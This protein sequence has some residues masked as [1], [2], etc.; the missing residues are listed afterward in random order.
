MDRV[1]SIHFV[2]GLAALMV[3]AYHLQPMLNA[4]FGTRYVSHLGAF[5]VDLFFVVSG[6]VMFIAAKRRPFALKR[7]A[8]ARFFRIVPLYWLAT[9]VI[10]GLFWVGF[11]PNGL[12]I[13]NWRILVRSLLFIPSEFERGRHDL[14][15]SLGW[16]L[17]YE[18]FFYGIFAFGSL[19]ETRLRVYFF[20][21]SVLLTAAW[22]GT[23]LPSDA[24]FLLTYYTKPIV[25]EF[26]Y[27]GAIA[28]WYSTRG[29]RKYDVL[30]AAALASSALA[31]LTRPGYSEVGLSE[32]RFL[33]FGLPAASLVVAG[34]LLEGSIARLPERLVVRP[35]SHLGDISYSLYLFHPLV[36]QATVKVFALI[37]A[38][39]ALF[40]PIAGFC[41]LIAAVVAASIIHRIVERP[42]LAWGKSF[43]LFS[44][45][46]AP[47]PVR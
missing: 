37:V 10:C 47:V 12:H 34:L 23:A 11:R 35:L 18:L 5:G 44:K 6:F 22:L 30:G 40:A 3:V 1:V 32:L 19:L 21:T 24:P 7:F 43:S 45:G 31:L 26:A 27:G 13:L 17:M 8:A 14:I 16:T 36:G 9:L 41:A 46:G 29:P 4:G 42:V 15:L 39:Q 2:R 38:G 28:L 25:L 20:V 33:A